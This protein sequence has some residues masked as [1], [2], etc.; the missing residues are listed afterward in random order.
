[1]GIVIKNNAFA[2]LATEINTTT[3]TF[4]LRSGNGGNFPNL[5]GT[6]YYYLTVT[7]GSSTP[8]I[9]KCVAKN[10]DVLTVVRGQEGTIPQTASAGSRIDL[11]VTAQSVL[12]V[13]QARAY[14][15]N[16][17][18]Y[19][20]VGD[21]TTDDT[22]AIQAAVNASNGVFFPAGT[23]KITTAITLKANSTVFGEGASSVI[24][25]FGTAG[26]QGALFANSGSA[27]AYID[28]IT[29][30]DL[31]VLGQVASLG[32][33][34]FVHLIS[35]SG[36]RNCVIE[37]CVIEG[38]RGDGIYIG[39]GDLGGQE[40]HNIGVTVRDCYINGV[41]N[42]NRNG[43][44]IIDGT[45]VNIDNNYFVN[46]T[47]SN[48][49]GAIDVEPDVN[50]YHIIRDISIRNNR[51]VSCGGN[52][53]NISI[54]LPSVV[55]T[56]MPNGFN[57][58]NNYVQSS[59]NSYGI[60]FTYGNSSGPALTESTAEFGIRIS[61]NVIN[62]GTV[63]GR[64]FGL[65][66]ANDAVLDGNQFI[67]GTT[68]FIGG[69]GVNVLDITLRNNMFVD[70]QYGVDPFAVAVYTGSRIKFESNI[71]K[72]CGPAVGALGG[73]IEFASGTTSYVDIIGNIFVSPSGS[74][75]QQAIR[76]SSHTFTGA[77]NRLIGN[78]LIAGANNF[79]ASINLNNYPTSI[80]NN[81]PNLGINAVPSAYR[82]S[83]DGA[84][85][86]AALFDTDDLNVQ[87]TSTNGT[88]NQA[89]GYAIG[90]FA[91]N[92]TLNNNPWGVVTNN[93]S[94]M[95]V[96]V[97]NNI[98]VT[99]ASRATTAT[100]GF[101]YLPSCAGTPTGTPRTY[102]DAVPVIVDRTN[103]KLYFYTNGSWRDAGP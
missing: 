82:L 58:E 10:G 11:R 28:N 62:Y 69:S 13:A 9:V 2:T 36:V 67:G 80:Y 15:V 49:P 66:N 35:V 70:V 30:S 19:G 61:K 101:L 52:V 42:D 92:G 57:I 37:R 59:T 44:S 53:G 81:I 23:Y 56:T 54:F 40:R 14:A 79:V 31:K 91:Y 88:V 7:S 50:V 39:S 99:N 26:G 21:G 71:F 16:V 68:S 55:Y 100:D 74:F 48:M 60:Y 75:T 87:I 93:T 22:V 33:S 47:R 64:G 4:L 96:D 51:M 95:Q 32:F 102:T 27:S 72:D 84:A 77:T 6:D 3:S 29:I 38:F 12:D 76:D 103:N 89:S 73:G 85:T 45:N 86:N 24:S 20:A 1:M 83:V 46:T 25:Y 65:G 90:G 78:S 97:H 94:R 17:K 43:I 63:T 98:I 18:S 5:S 34:E 8:E 41:N